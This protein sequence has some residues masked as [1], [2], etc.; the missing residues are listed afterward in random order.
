MATP[1]LKDDLAP[2]LTEVEGGLPLSQSLDRSRPE[3][4]DLLRR[5]C[6]PKMLDLARTSRRRPH[7]LHRSRSRGGPHGRKY[8]T[9]E[10]YD[11]R[12]S[13]QIHHPNAANLQVTDLPPR[14]PRTGDKSQVT[15]SD[16]RAGGRR[17]AAGQGS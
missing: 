11:P 3:R 9:E 15:L 14:K 6:R 13:A 8:A 4:L 17:V 2:Y 12:F 1:A 16:E 10:P 7:D 5:M